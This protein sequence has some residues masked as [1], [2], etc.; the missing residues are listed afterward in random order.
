MDKS[1]KWGILGAGKIAAK[2]A[3]DLNKTDGCELVAVASTSLERAQQFAIEHQIRYSFGCYDDLFGV[4]LDVIYIAT[5]HTF[6][7]QHTLLCLSQGVGVLCEKPFAMN[8]SE[9]VEMIALAKSKNVF[10]MEAMWSR[11]M[12]SILAAKS[13]IDAG[14]I[15]VI[16]TIHADFG[17]NAV[18]DEKSRL[19]DPALGGGAFLDIGIYPAFLSLFLLGYPSKIMAASIFASTGTDETTSF[20]YQY[21]N[22]STALLN[23]TVS[24]HTDCDARIYGTLGSIKIHGR[25]H[26]ASRITYYNAEG[27]E[28]ETLNFERE[29]FGY[30]YE[31]IEVN[32]CLREGLSE[33]PNWSLAD[34]N[35]LIHLLDKTREAAKIIYG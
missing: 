3:S 21:D 12:P 26:D 1:I 4:E 16:K 14:N 19:F 34:S 24:T 15:G 7:K 17:F 5:P 32:R 13:C 9:V 30:N 23:C 29:T 11:F 33:S 31:I 18:F 22:Q 27:T 10:L 35:K 8:E 28:I 20:I 2:F 6:H 25:F